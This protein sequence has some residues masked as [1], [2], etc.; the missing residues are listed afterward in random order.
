[1]SYL[2][3]GLTGLLATAILAHAGAAS[4]NGRFP[5]AGDIVFNRN[6]A[7]HMMV[8]TTYGF[9]QTKDAGRNWN[10]ICEAALDIPFQPYDPPVGLTGDGTSIISVTF[11]GVRTSR[12]FCSWAAS[13]SLLAGQLV[14]DITNIPNNN[15]GLYVISSTYNDTAPTTAPYDNLIVETRNNGLTWAL[16]ARLPGN[17]LL[18]TI[19]VA[20]SDPN[21][22]YLTALPFP[23]L[24]GTTRSAIFLRTE[25]G[26]STWTNITVPLPPAEPD[27]NGLVMEPSLYIAGVDPNNVDRIYARVARN[28]WDTTG[29]PPSVLRVSHDKG[30]TWQD[31]YDTRNSVTIEDKSMLGFALS[32]DGRNMVFGG[33]FGVFAGPA[34]AGPFTKVH[35]M[36]NRC[37]KWTGA[38]I[39]ACATQTQNPAFSDPYTVG[40]STDGGHN[41][42]SVFERVT[43]T[44][45]LT[46]A[47]GTPVANTCPKAWY[48]PTNPDPNRSV[49]VL[50]GATCGDTPGG[51]SPAASI[52][53]WSA[54]NA[55]LAV[56]GGIL[57]VGAVAFA[58]WWRRRRDSN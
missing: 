4:A 22:I 33:P 44:C 14:R 37:L 5:A 13:P 26:G 10:W 56:P 55:R 46:C 3:S 16:K 34:P 6:N 51:C 8:R 31:L 12:D 32:P 9:L 52:S 18:E 54:S 58:W 29:R 24:S 21:R 42:R 19:E 1:M 36:Q 43:Q 40:L 53:P 23:P 57:A 27:E 25:N 41:F 17:L 47:A 45:P 49:K 11:G 28:A 39:Y 7:S 15:D 30:A 20:S 48:D 2:R 35:N 50:I 38:G